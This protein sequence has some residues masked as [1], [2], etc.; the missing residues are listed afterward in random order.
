MMVTNVIQISFLTVLVIA[1]VLCVAGGGRNWIKMRD[2][3]RALGME[4]SAAMLARSV[5][6][7][8]VCFYNVENELMF[9]GNGNGG[10]VSLPDEPFEP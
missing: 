3:I 8:V 4:L 9:P 6:E 5:N 2:Q 7:H 10:M 1:P